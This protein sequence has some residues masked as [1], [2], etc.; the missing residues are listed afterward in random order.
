MTSLTSTPHGVVSGRRHG[1]SRAARSYQRMARSARVS[2]DRD[3][4][5]VA[6]RG[7]RA[8]APQGSGRAPA[9]HSEIV[10]LT[11]GPLPAAVYWRR[12][13][14]VLVSLA[15]VVLVVSYRAP[16]RT[17]RPRAPGRPASRRPAS[18][19]P[20]TTRRAATP[21]AT[22]TRRV[23]PAGTAATGPCA[24]AE[25]GPSATAGQRVRPTWT[26][27]RPDHQDQEHLGPHV[28]PR[29]RRRRA[30]AATCRTEP[31]RLVLGRLQRPQ[32][33]RRRGRWRRARRRR[34]RSPGPATGAVRRPGRGLQRR[35]APTRRRYQLVGAAGPEAERAVSAA[36]ADGT[37]S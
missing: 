22:P 15:M 23:H 20:T 33:H 11:V 4:A 37:P 6:A 7:P 24:D 3:P 17:H 28:Q 13:A 26:V 21:T 32:G 19:A 16:A 1:R 10:R 34:S 18:I 2:I 31:A 30:G 29:R 25:I 35:P 27:D 36:P 8:G 14:V 12:R 9:L 5:T